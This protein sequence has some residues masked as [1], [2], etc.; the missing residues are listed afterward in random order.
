M[1]DKAPVLDLLWKIKKLT[2]QET[3]ERINFA[4]LLREREYRN[5]ILALARTSS[6]PDLLDLI[7]RY[8]NLDA[9]SVEHFDMAMVDA[10]FTD[11]PPVPV[12]SNTSRSRTFLISG[13]SLFTG[14]L[15][16]ICVLFGILAYW[17][18]STDRHQAV[19]DSLLGN[20]T[21]SSYTVNQT[22]EEAT[23]ALRL[24]SETSEPTPDKSLGNLS[25]ET[26]DQVSN[27]ST[28][29]STQNSKEPQQVTDIATQPSIPSDHNT[30]ADASLRATTA[31]MSA[32]SIKDQNSDQ[33]PDHELADAGIETPTPE[34]DE[35]N[36]SADATAIPAKKILR[37]HGSNTVG[38]ALAPALLDAYFRQDGATEIQRKRGAGDVEHD[39]L[40]TYPGREDAVSVEVHA[41]GSSTAFKGLM[42]TEADMGMSSRAIKSQEIQDLEPMYGNFAAQGSEF[43]IA[44]DGLAVIVHPANPLNSLS[45]EQVARLFAGELTDWAQLGGRSGPVSIFAR[46]ENSGTWD[47]F[48]NLVLKKYDKSLSPTASRYESSTELSDRVA[49]DVNAI[50]FIGLPYVRSSKALGIADGENV[51][52]VIPTSFTVSTEDY[53]L[54]RRLYFYVPQFINSRN[55]PGSHQIMQDLARFTLSEKGQEIVREVGFISQNIRTFQPDLS[56]GDFPLAYLEQTRDAS[57][58]SLN[59]RFAL[60]SDQFDTKAVNDLDRLVRFVENNPNKSLMLFGFTDNIGDPS[61]NLNLSLRRARSVQEALQARGISPSVVNGFGQAA[62]VASN[63]NQTGRNKNRRVEVWVK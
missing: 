17:L 62:P 24:E 25:G 6:N 42:K 48:K 60:G 49:S 41:H 2:D 46:D 51:S 38:E 18:V 20:P 59:I 61:V 39:V 7:A 30:A 58:L 54:S 53:P 12:K 35:V 63:D 57:R 8:E 15:A 32:P 50:G 5:G 21:R 13:L 11:T 28:R 33:L 43:V 44:L 31:A 37:L 23:T 10:D 40:V 14:L 1:N 36:A 34:V 47:T 16:G 22:P 29:I 26:S 45:S 9:E 19:L 55:I 4:Q 56:Q 3:G 27:T 52:A